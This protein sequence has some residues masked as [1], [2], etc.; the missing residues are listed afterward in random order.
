DNVVVVLLPLR[1]VRASRQEVSLEVGTARAVVKVEVVIS[2]FSNPTSLATIELLGLTE[3]AEV[4]MIGPDLKGMWCTHKE[5]TPFREG[6]HDGEK[7]TVINFIVALGGV[8]GFGKECD[9]VPDVIL[10]L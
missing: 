10:A 7:L 8:K 1:M 5:M 6:G 4:Q 9:R 2:K 3:I